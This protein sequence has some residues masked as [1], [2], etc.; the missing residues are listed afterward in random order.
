MVSVRAVFRA[1]GRTASL[2]MRPL[3][4]LQDWVGIATTAL[5]F[6]GIGTTLF[7]ENRIEAS[8]DR[9]LPTAGSRVCVLL[10]MVALLV[11]VAACKL[12]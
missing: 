2:A 5:L 7:T 11:F 8:L 12:N 4:G 3:P 9:Y 1:V 10:G 6:A